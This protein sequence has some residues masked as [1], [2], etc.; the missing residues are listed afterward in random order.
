MVHIWESGAGRRVARL[1]PVLPHRRG[2]HDV[3]RPAGA[4]GM[5]EPLARSDTIRMLEEAVGLIRQTSPRVLL[6]H[7]IGSVPFALALLWSWSSIAG[8]HT[9]DAAWARQSFILALLLMW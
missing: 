7:W 8:V 3:L 1:E 4:N 6:T 9:T 5:A 2:H